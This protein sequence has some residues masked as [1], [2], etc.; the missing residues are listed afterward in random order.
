MSQARAYA[1]LSAKSP[2]VPFQFSR[3][4]LGD[5][6]VSIAIDYCGICHTDLHQMRND[7][8]GATFPMVP[9]HEIVGR[10]TQVGRKARKLKI[11]DPAGVGCM[12]NSC[13]KCAN[14]KKGLEQHC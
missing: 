10:V 12:V 3:R 5:K 2:L 6:D 7:W 4:E 14:C 8:G 9:G 11:G 13:R 1:A